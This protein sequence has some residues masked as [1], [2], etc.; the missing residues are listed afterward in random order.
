M[1]RPIVIAAGQDDPRM[2]T[3]HGRY[4]A[5]SPDVLA[6][7]LRW[8]GAISRRELLVPCAWTVQR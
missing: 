8:C 6:A 4:R 3:K 5:V 7:S 1:V 2:Q